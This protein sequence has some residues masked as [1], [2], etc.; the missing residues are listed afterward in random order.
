MGAM[1]CLE[2]IGDDIVP[3][4]T[5]Q[6]GIA[7]GAIGVGGF[8]ENVAFVDE[9]EADFA[10]DFASAVKS[11]RRSGGLVAELEIGMEG[12]EVERDAGAEMR[13][14]P[15]GELASFGGIVVERGDDEIGELKP[16]MGFVLEPG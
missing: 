13:E 15:L 16:D 14:D 5:D 11:A 4:A 9:V 1:P 8:G 12:G 2:V 7:G 6:E 3:G 10:S